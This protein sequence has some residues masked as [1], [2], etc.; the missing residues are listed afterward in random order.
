MLCE[1]Y[2][3]EISVFNLLFGQLALILLLYIPC[4]RM[5]SPDCYLMD[6]LSDLFNGKKKGM[7][8]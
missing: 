5:S 8:K 6:L 2:Q 4:F 7:V 3:L 1:C